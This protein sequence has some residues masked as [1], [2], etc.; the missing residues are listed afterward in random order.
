MK[1]YYFRVLLVLL[2]VSLLFNNLIRILNVSYGNGKNDIYS[3]SEIVFDDIHSKKNVSDSIDFNLKSPNFE[4]LLNPEY[5]ICRSSNQT[6]PTL[7]ALVMT[8]P[9]DFKKRSLIRHTWASTPMSNQ[10][11][12]SQM[13]TIFLL[14]ISNNNTINE[15]IKLEYNQYRDVIQQNFTDSYHNL[16]L[17]TILGLQWSSIYCANSRFI[18]KIDD[19]IV[20]NRNALINYLNHA[21]Q[22]KLNNTMICLIHRKAKVQR[23]RSSK[24]Y[25]PESVFAEPY[26]SDYCDGEAYLFTSDLSKKF[27]KETLRTKPFIFE[28]VYIG[29]IAAKLKVT[30][31]DFSFRYKLEKY[32]GVDKILNVIDFNKYFFVLVKKSPNQDSTYSQIWNEFNK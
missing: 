1:L 4:F 3:N 16:T 30:L 10:N 23:N 26:Y 12:K 17:K 9:S 24:F 7:L 18:L 5:T 21:N 11:N 29:Q 22:I 32:I 15:Q 20:L 2:F 8:L 19:D 27:Y 31:L 13:R 28:D 14:G 25:V 6:A